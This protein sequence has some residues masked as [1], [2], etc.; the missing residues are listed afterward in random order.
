MVDVH[1]PCVSTPIAQAVTY[2]LRA[3]ETGSP[4]KWTIRSLERGVGNFFEKREHSSNLAGARPAA[5]PYPSA[6]REL[7]DKFGEDR[8]VSV[9]LNTLSDTAVRARRSARPLSL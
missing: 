2:L 7:L 3:D 8:H 4:E 1:W 6:E 9:G 5:A